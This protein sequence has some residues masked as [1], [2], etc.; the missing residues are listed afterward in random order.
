MGHVPYLI[1]KATLR[2]YRSPR[3]LLSAFPYPG[4][5]KRGYDIFAGTRGELLLPCGEVARFRAFHGHADMVRMR[6]PHLGWQRPDPPPKQAGRDST[7]V[8]E[9]A[10]G[11]ETHLCKCMDGG[12]GMPMA[13]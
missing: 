6:S 11:P 7:D 10:D 12:G 9:G 4:I 3:D 5:F 1:A 2:L 13:W 8:A